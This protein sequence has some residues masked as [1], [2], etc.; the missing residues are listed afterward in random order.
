[1]QRPC[2]GRDGAHTVPG[3]ATG[4][5]SSCGETRRHYPVPPLP[6]QRLN[7]RQV[8]SVLQALG[9][10]QEGGHRQGGQKWPLR[11]PLSACSAPGST[12]PLV[13]WCWAITRALNW[14][15]DRVSFNIFQELS[16]RAFCCC[17]LFHVPRVVYL[18]MPIAQVSLL[19]GGASGSDTW[20]R[21]AV[22]GGDPQHVLLPQPAKQDLDCLV[23]LVVG[24]CPVFL[25]RPLAVPQSKSGSAACPASTL[26]RCSFSSPRTLA[27]VSGR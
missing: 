3:C 11:R 19:W 25:R 21:A 16:G 6:S 17:M 26:T 20:N 27:L 24:P 12:G 22:Q 13:L 15:E 7:R 10:G 1:M 8:T 2:P 5:Q 4:S 9:W 14:D 18:R 23:D